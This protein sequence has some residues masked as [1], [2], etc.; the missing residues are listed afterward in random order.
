MYWGISSREVGSEDLMERM[1]AMRVSEVVRV[2]GEEEHR[3][4]VH[5]KAQVEWREDWRVEK[6]VRGGM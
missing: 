5:V 4:Q 6:G 2:S 3:A 1:S